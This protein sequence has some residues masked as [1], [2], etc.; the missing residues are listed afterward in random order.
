MSQDC[1]F[2]RIIAG[3]I[4]NRTVY[5]DDSVIAFLDVNPLVEGH[6]LVVPKK[7]GEQVADLPEVAPTVFQRAA[8]LTPAVRDAADA[9]GTT[10]AVNDGPAAGQE[11]PH[12]HVHIVPR[13]TDDSAGMLHTLDWPRPDLDDAAFGTIQAA[14]RSA[15]DM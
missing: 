7:H 13:V 12:L 14:I 6:T 2:C 15:S 4:P 9:S 5:E 3:D 11:V 10:V 8:E 1:I